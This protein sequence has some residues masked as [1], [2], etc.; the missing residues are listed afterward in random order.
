M[1]RTVLFNRGSPDATEVPRFCWIPAESGDSN[2]IA[3]RTNAYIRC[4]SCNV[5]LLVND[6][7][8]ID[9]NG[10]VSPCVWCQSCDDH[11]WTRLKDWS[12]G[13]LYARRMIRRTMAVFLKILKAANL[14]NLGLQ[15]NSCLAREL[16]NGYF[17]CM[18]YQMGSDRTMRHLSRIQV[19]YFVPEQEQD[20]DCTAELLHNLL[21]YSDSSVFSPKELI[22]F[23]PNKD[24]VQPKLFGLL[25]KANAKLIGLMFPDKRVN[26][27][28][29]CPYCLGVSAK[30]VNWA[31][32]ETSRRNLTDFGFTVVAKT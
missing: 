16:A 24:K 18:L 19:R 5:I 31:L 2:H 14:G 32:D 10:V 7:F 11:I 6:S 12:P 28:C 23:L 22:R 25:W 13:E 20:D 4:P 26:I 21:V 27:P 9:S 29:T 30:G 17:N 15:P 8:D 1:E 3:R